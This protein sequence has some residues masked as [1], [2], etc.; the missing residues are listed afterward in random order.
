MPASTFQFPKLLDKSIDKMYLKEYTAHEREFSKLAKVAT[1]PKGASYTEAEL[2][3]LGNLREVPEG[4]GI[5]FD[6]PVEGNEKT[7]RYTAYGLGFQV[8]RQM[9]DDDLQNLIMKMPQKLGR[10]AAVK[11]EYLFFD[12]FNNGFGAQTAWDGQPIFDTAHPKLKTGG[13]YG[14]EPSVAGALSSTTFQAACEYYD[15]LEDHAGMPLDFNGKR[16][17]LIPTALKYTAKQLM[18]NELVLGSANNDLNLMNPANNI[19]DAFSLHV[20]RFLTSATAWFLLDSANHDFRLYW[21]TQAGLESSDDFSTG[22]R[23]YKTWMRLAAFV[24]DPIGA[25][26]NPGA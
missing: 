11:P 7:I 20:S 8:T 2:S 6:T 26:G 21:K 23:L 10:S 14:N 13:T 5:Q 4:T 17:L 25:Y 12:L 22:N 1:A 24:M 18:K 9:V 15:G 19:V 3:G 16:V